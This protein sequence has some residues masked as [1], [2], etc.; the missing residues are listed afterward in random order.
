[1]M[2]STFLA[3]NSRATNIHSITVGK[4]MIKDKFMLPLIQKLSKDAL[5][6]KTLGTMHLDDQKL[7]SFSE[8]DILLMIQGADAFVENDHKRAAF[9]AD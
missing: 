7:Y 3:A 5:A 2:S 8:N 6:A 9:Y 4:M 1:M